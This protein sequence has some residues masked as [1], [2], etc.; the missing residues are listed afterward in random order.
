MADVYEAVIGL[1]V[2]A[3]LATNSKIF[4]SCAS[5]F[6]APPNTHICPVCMGLPG[7]LPTLNKQAVALALKAGLATGCKINKSSRFDRKNYFYPDLPKAYQISQYE[8]PL[9][10]GGEITVTG[11]WGE[12]RIGITRIHLEEDAG[13]LIHDGQ[14]T[15]L[16]DYNRCGVP[17]IEI[18]S[19][20]ELNSAEEAKA[21]LNELRT[22]LLYAGVSHCRMN[23][24]ELRCDVNISVRKKGDAVLGT[25]AEIKN[26]NSFSFVGKAIDYELQRQTELLRNGGEVLSET[27]R[28]DPDTGR[29]YPMR[30]KERAE[31]YRFF[32]EPDLLPLSVSED[33]LSKLEGELPTMPRERRALYTVEYG[34]SEADARILASRLPLAE[35]FEET[36]RLTPYRKDA[37]NL[38][39][40]ELSSEFEE[41][42][43]AVCPVSPSAL[44]ETATLYGERKIN[45]STAKALIKE[46][47]SGRKFSPVEEVREKGLE[48]INDR[49][50]LDAL[51]GEVLRQDER[52]STDLKNGKRNAHKA[53]MGKVMAKTSGLADP[54]VLKSIV[55]ERIKTLI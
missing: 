34:I 27:R 4:C 35:Y 17:L 13:K 9:C 20:P 7:T 10:Y 42:A 33:I 38:L 28:F 23:R 15:T 55:D 46:L 43:T 8:L 47:L 30:V 48:Q 54:C 6:G 18:V 29:T 40:G 45:S 1:E 26:I 53:L 44:A 24:G 32:A 37:A 22:I 14:N 2:H 49:Q 21:Y 25:R 36:A 11:E 51:L 19:E 16:I 5:E 31:D 41:E 3:E 12:K 39:L 52:L 50:T